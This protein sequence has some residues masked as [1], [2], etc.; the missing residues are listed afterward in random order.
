MG[1]RYNENGEVTGASNLI[2]EDDGL[3][4]QSSI[5]D[6]PVKDEPVK[7]ASY[8][9]KIVWRN[10]ILFTIL[11]LGALYGVYSLLFE[12]KWLT[13]LWCY[14]LLFVSATGITAGAHRLWAH[15]SYKAK[16]PLKFILVIF[17][18]VSFQNDIIEW[19]RDHRVHHK[20][21]ETNADPHNALRG[22]FFAH[23]GW[24]LVRK[25]PDVAMKGKGVDISDLTNC[26]LLQFQRKYYRSLVIFFCFIVPSVVPMLWGES[27]FVAYFT[28][29]LLRYCISLNM[30]WC[31]NS[32]A[33]M[34][35]FR[36]YDAKINPRQNYLTSFGAFGEGWHNYHHSFPYDYR[37]SEFPY[38]LNPT[39]LFIDVFTWIGWVYDRKIVSQEI[40]DK[41]KLKSGEHSHHHHH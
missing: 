28:A 27:A 12:A 26:P 23:I 30:T 41:K 5:K 7:K 18:C 19:A 32:V 25:H 24:L 10:V 38:T 2:P 11:H 15:K 4:L 20:Y 9:M 8:E 37:A 35:G 14:F 36:P 29:G 16:T 21:S 40:I 13:W 34:W 3:L 6:E 22:F 39:T 17:N 31:V 33:H 1:P